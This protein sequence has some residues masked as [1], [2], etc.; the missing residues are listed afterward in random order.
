MRGRRPSFSST[1]LTVAPQIVVS[2]TLATGTPNCPGQTGQT[3]ASTPTVPT[4]G[5]NP[6][7]ALFPHVGKGPDVSRR[8]AAALHLERRGAGQ[9]ALSQDAKARLPRAHAN[10]DQCPLGTRYVA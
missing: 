1:V 4:G 8:Q 10:A 5:R 3:A 6:Q 7:K 2:C 9:P